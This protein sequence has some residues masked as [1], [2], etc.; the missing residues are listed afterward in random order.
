MSSYERWRSF[1]IVEEVS[2]P[3]GREKDIIGGVKNALERGQSLQE[4]KQS[5]LNSGY[6]SE[7]IE[8]AVQMVPQITSKISKLL[9]GAEPSKDSKKKMAKERKVKNKEEPEEKAGAS[10]G[11][12]IGLIIMSLLV[13]GG[14]IFMFFFWEQLFP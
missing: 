10:K 2:A 1:K 13:V 7:E 8:A 5:F 9:V 11:L 6:R 12:V 14:G 3:Q 4:V